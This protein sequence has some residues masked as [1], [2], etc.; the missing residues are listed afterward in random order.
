[1]LF[2]KG[3]L[4][5]QT[6]FLVSSMSF[7]L[8]KSETIHAKPVKILADTLFLKSLGINP[9]ASDTH[10][11]LS[12]AEVSEYQADTI[13]HAAHKFHKCGGFE[14]LSDSENITQ[15][16]AMM[17]QLRAQA[18]AFEFIGKP[19]PNIEKKTE[20]EA[21]TKLVSEENLRA[22][23]QWLSSY[24][25]RYHKGDSKH[26][27]DFA[28]RIKQ[29]LS[30][31]SYSYQVDLINHTQTKQKSLRV[32]LQG[33]DHPEEVVILGGHLD[34]IVRMGG[35]APGADDN[36]SGSSNILEALRIIATQPQASRS[37][38]FFWYAGEEGGLIGSSEIA[39]N[40][41]QANAKVIGVLQLDMTLYPGEGE[42]V[43]GDM[44]DF[45]SPWLRNYVKTLNN[46]YVGAQWK[47]D[48]CG[49]GC[50]DHASWH[51]QGY[52]TVMPFEAGFN[53]MNQN[54]HTSKDIIT[55]ALNF[56]HSAA[57]AKLAL[58][59]AMDLSNSSL[60]PTF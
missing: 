36:A 5:S 24:P 20:I 12:T 56:K 9:T 51:R 26:V 27:E 16:F 40:Y 10:L 31:L 34:S 54:I 3:V 60:K 11:K 53:T 18:Q 41:K 43:M 28:E 2:K 19:V 49:Y 44:T 25:S 29:M 38:E 21:A 6:L 47:E 8:L 50:S 1:M 42:L 32:H 57:F 58:A 15:S 39:Q 59:Y 7:V 45:T 33:K 30:G 35:P 52:A 22:T 48:E 46:F 23:V 17:N 37:I 13:S 55:P 14:R 4:L